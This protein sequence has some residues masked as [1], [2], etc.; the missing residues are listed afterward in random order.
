MIIDATFWVMI[1]FFTFLGLLIY[2]KIPQKIRTTL[3]ENI[4][5]MSKEIINLKKIQNPTVVMELKNRDITLKK[6]IIEKEESEKKLAKIKKK[7]E[8]EKELIM[9]ILF[10]ILKS[11]NLT[12]V[13]HRKT[14]ANY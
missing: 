6:M 14:G 10:L 4:Y 13:H 8:K 12:A 9:N 1:S 2:F 5:N 11:D 7:F 3:E